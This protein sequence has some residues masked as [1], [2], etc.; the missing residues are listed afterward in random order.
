LG[1]ENESS[2]GFVLPKT[3]GEGFMDLDEGKEA[4]DL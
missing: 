1:S 3:T 2:P 4:D